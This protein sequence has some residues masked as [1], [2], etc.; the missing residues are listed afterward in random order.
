MTGYLQCTGDAAVQIDADGED[1]PMTVVSFIEKWE[2]GYEVVYGTRRSRAEGWY[3]TALRKLF[4]RVM[5]RLSTVPVPVDA[6]DF[7]LV[8]RKVIEHLRQFSETTLYVR[9][10]I[11]YIGFNQIGVP[12]D[13]RPRYDG[14]SK[15][16]WWQAIRMAWHAVASLSGWP[17]LIVAYLGVVF[18]GVTFVLT[19]LYVSLHR[20]LDF[21]LS[22]AVLI[23]L[24]AF[25][26][27]GVQLFGMGI[28]GAYVGRIFEEVKQ[29]PRSIVECVVRAEQASRPSA[30]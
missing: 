23:F 19:I 7:R 11:S 17:L 18:S 9:G 12:Y 21:P 8:D 25:F 20:V 16:S 5:A 1:D 29:R 4:Y 27:V 14:K 10:L 13:R 2:Q 28:I 24:A 30:D 3:V 22:P 6:G 26:L 15:F